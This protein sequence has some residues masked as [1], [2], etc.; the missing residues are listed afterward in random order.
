M[1]AEVWLSPV[2]SSSSQPEPASA[3]S[4]SIVSR[5]CVGFLMLNCLASSI[6]MSS[7]STSRVRKKIHHGWKFL[8]QVRKMIS[9]VSH[10]FAFFKKKLSEISA[11]TSFQFQLSPKGVTLFPAR[12]KQYI[13]LLKPPKN[14]EGLLDNFGG[15]TGISS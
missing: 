4:S 3:Q 12:D 14:W 1:E 6:W 9:C 15:E 7:T 8:V 13:R 10:E 2:A 5:T 11:R